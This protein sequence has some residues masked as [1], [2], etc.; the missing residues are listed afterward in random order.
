[1]NPAIT[2]GNGCV[3][4][5]DGHAIT[6]PA[7]NRGSPGFDGMLARNALGEVAQMQGA[8]VPVTFG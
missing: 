4:D 8:G 1:V 3:P 5:T 7:G 2:N 6:D